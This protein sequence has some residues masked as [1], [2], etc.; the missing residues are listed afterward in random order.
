MN[1]AMANSTT[2]ATSSANTNRALNRV[3]LRT[4]LDPRTQIDRDY[5]AGRW[6]AMRCDAVRGCVVWCGVI[7]AN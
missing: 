5:Y 2:T 6:L 1:T 3:L 4:F 7:D